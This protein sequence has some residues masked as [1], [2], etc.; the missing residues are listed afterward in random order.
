MLRI[1]SL[2]TNGIILAIDITPPKKLWP[3]IYIAHSQKAKRPHCLIASAIVYIHSSLQNLCTAC[4]KTSAPIRCISTLPK[5]KRADDGFVMIVL[6]LL[7]HNAN[8]LLKPSKPILGAT[9]NL[10]GRLE[11]FVEV[12]TVATDIPPSALLLGG[13]FC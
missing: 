1:C 5:S 8:W 6:R 13:P 12:S 2:K 10:Q 3:T 9:P 7:R 4:R 11:D